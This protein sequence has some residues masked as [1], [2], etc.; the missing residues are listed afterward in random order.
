MLMNRPSIS[1][2]TTAPSTPWPSACTKP[3]P[4]L[5]LPLPPAAWPRLQ[6]KPASGIGHT[7]ASSKVA[8]QVSSVV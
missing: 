6:P 5:P 1:H 3:P 8:A 7:S 4:P 2:T